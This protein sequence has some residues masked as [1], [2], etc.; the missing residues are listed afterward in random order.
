M[1]VQIKL[2]QWKTTKAKESLQNA[3]GETKSEPRH[4]D[5]GL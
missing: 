2:E 4:V 5:E 1:E 3:N